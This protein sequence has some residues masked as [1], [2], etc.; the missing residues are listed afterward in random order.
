MERKSKGDIIVGLCFVVA[1]LAFLAGGVSLGISGKAAVPGPGPGFFPAL[2][3]VFSIFFGLWIAIEAV[4]KGS[5]DFFGTDPEQLSN[6]KL[7]AFVTAV[8]ILFMALWYFLNFYVGVAALCLLYNFAFG[9][10]WKFN[11]IFSAVILGLLYFIFE[12]LLSVQFTI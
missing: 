3:A 5:V 12:R 7:I 11:L 2:C 9:R 8:F 4:K 10:T 1:G 6:G